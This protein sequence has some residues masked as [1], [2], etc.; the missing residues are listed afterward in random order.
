DP[1][2]QCSCSSGKETEKDPSKAKKKENGDQTS[3]PKIFF[4]T[5]T[6]KQ[7]SQIT[8]ELKRT[9]Y[10]GVP[11]TILSSRDYTCIHPVVSSSTSNRNEMCV[12]LLEGK[13]GKS[14][15][16][17]HG[18]HKLSEYHTL[19]LAHQKCQAW[20]IE[21][22]VSLGKKLRACA[23]F[24]ARELML[25]ADIV[26][27]PYNYLLDPQI[28]ESMDI[29]L[30][31]QVVILDEAHNIEDSARESV[32]YSVTENQLRSAREELDL[33]VN[34]NIRQKDHEPLRAVCCSLT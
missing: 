7:I 18:V 8:R 34:N 14:C 11:M 23:Y 17:Y 29:N 24:A 19:Q 26:F 25:G 31:G 6:H 22:L 27:C 20:D 1:C 4:G 16:Y 3:I 13:H 12:E 10:S 32:S 30:K 33:M 15:L 28:R 9:A 5:R 21:D 2:S